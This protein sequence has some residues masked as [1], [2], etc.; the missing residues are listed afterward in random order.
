MIIGVDIRPMAGLR[1]GIQEY[2]EQILAHLIAIA[3]ADVKF[4]LFFASSRSAAPNLSWMHAPNVEL[5][6]FN[7]PNNILFFS[8]SVWGYPYLDDLIGGADVF[9]SPHFFLA[10]LSHA[11]RRVTTFHDL[12]YVRFPEFFTSRKRWWHTIQ[13]NPGE[14]ARFSDQIIAVS[15]STKNDLIEH[16][17]IDP[18]NIR[19]V[20][21][22]NHMVRPPDEAIWE[23]KKKR[24]L[25]DRTVLFLG[26]IEPRKNIGGLIRAFNIMKERSGFEDVELV[27][28]GKKGWQFDDVLEEIERSPFAPA[29][30]CLGHIPDEDRSLY[31]ASS[32]VFVYPSFFEGF[33]SPVLEAMACGAPVITSANSSLPEVAGDAALFIDPYNVS[34]IAEALRITLS[35]PV[36]RARMIHKGFAQAQKFSWQQS[37]QTTLEILMKR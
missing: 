28:A 9:F 14:Q 18:S 1:T 7:I 3:P 17:H 24:Q 23:F 15:Q 33:G 31:Y 2:T 22:G 12:S 13:M 36:V 4:K 30:R 19:V 8:G 37:A 16:Y 20:P 21:L 6:K 29:I 35:D 10:P 32:S 5:V 11:C 34:D 27:I 25:A 26:T